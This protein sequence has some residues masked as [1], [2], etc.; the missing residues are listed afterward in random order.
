[1]HAHSKRLLYMNSV[2]AV[3][4]LGLLAYVLCRPRYIDLAIPVPKHEGGGAFWWET[5]RTILTLDDEPGCIFVLRRCGTAYS[6]THGWKDEEDIIHYFEKYLS[7]T[8]WTQ[9]SVCND[10]HPYM[11]EGYFLPSGY[12]QYTRTDDPSGYSG[13]VALAVWPVG[14]GAQSGGFHV[15]LVTMNPSLLNELLRS[16]D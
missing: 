16:I 12:L 7:A 1:M 10:G 2:I 14:R 15:T 5:H 13:F 9:R 3:V 8:G 11:P 4:V 6:D